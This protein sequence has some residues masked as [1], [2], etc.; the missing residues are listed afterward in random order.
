MLTFLTMQGNENTN[1][2]VLNKISPDYSFVTYPIAQPID[3]PSPSRLCVLAHS[4][5]LEVA[6]DRDGEPR[7]SS[8]CPSLALAVLVLQPP[9]SPASSLVLT[10]DPSHSH[11]AVWSASSTLAAKQR[12]NCVISRDHWSGP[13]LAARRAACLNQA[14]TSSAPRN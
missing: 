6:W 13:V 1:H 9:P 14:D 7:R 4:C 2:L 10:M 3:R 5:H 8:H 12:R 11:S